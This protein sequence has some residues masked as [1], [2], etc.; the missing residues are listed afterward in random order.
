MK[1]IYETILLR[2]IEQTK[3]A[4]RKA[5]IYETPNR[6]VTCQIILDT[7]L[8]TYHLYMAVQTQPNT[9]EGLK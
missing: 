6:Q 2:E 1:D 8:H 9:C 7:L 4:I 5:D 3:I